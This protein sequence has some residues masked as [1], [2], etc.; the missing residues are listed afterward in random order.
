MRPERQRPTS[1]YLDPV[2]AQQ[3]RE[4]HRELVYRWTRGLQV[5][6]Y[7]KTDLF[8]EANGA[9]QI[10]FDL[11]P[12]PCRAIGMDL[13]AATATEAARRCPSDSARFMA[14]DARH[15][16]LRPGSLDLIVSTSTL[17]HLESAEQFRASLAELSALLRGGGVLIITVDNPQNPLYRPLRWASH[18]G[19]LPFVLGYTPKLKELKDFLIEL[20]LEVLG[21][22][23]I[24]HNPRAFST[25][26]WM[27][28]RKFLKKRADLPIRFFLGLFALLGRLP[29]R[30]WTG[31]FSAVYA[32]CPERR[33]GVE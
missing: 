20:Q 2:V 11:Y 7:L 22:D 21:G 30:R 32:R 25:L 17:D 16:A 13:S 31:C 19:W 8:E 23:W 18:R 24:L 29:T 4:V 3:K 26:L 28:L 12:P 1:W 27:F 5:G 10:L 6:T 15:V 14:C 33:S 9:D